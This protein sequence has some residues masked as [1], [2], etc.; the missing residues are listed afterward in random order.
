MRTPLLLL[1][2]V[3]TEWCTMRNL[4]LHPDVDSEASLIRL[5]PFPLL[6]FQMGLESAC[7]TNTQ[8]VLQPRHLNSPYLHQPRARA[9]IDTEPLARPTSKQSKPSKQVSKKTL[10]ALSLKTLIL[11]QSI[12][13]RL[14][15]L[16]PWKTM[17]LNWIH[18]S[19]FQTR[20]IQV[21]PLGNH[22]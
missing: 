9:T 1:L 5:C 12:H 8:D 2:S 15:H 10:L 22:Q 4:R 17:P 20:R 3:N 16:P 19:L 13:L 21:P 7:L 18:R 14:I 6:E 11:Y